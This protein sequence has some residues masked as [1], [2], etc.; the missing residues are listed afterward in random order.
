MEKTVEDNLVIIKNDDHL[1]KLVKKYNNT[2]KKIRK[3]NCKNKED[4]RKLEKLKN[5]KEEYN[6]DIIERL[7]KYDIIFPINFNTLN[8]DE[9][10]VIFI[11]NY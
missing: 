5:I 6:A 4:K 2:I 7:G 8:T 3:L 10:T 11:Q 9:D 1:I